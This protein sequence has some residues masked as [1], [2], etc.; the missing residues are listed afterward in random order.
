MAMKAPGKHY[1][2]GITLIEL[3]QMFPDEDAARKW[4][5]E[6]RWPNG[7]RFCP[8]CGS[9]KVS[10]VQT[11]KPLPYWCTDCREYFSIKTGSVMHRSKVP[12]HKWAIAIYLMSTSLK[13]V[14]SM[15]LHRDLG[16]TQKTAWLMAQKIRTG[17]MQG[18]DM[19][20][21]PVEVDETYIGGKER[22]KHA[23]KKLRAGRGPVGKTAVVGMKDRSTNQ[24]SAEVVRV[25]EEWGGS[26]DKPTLQGFVRGNAAPGA[27]LF[28]DDN[29]CYHDMVDFEHES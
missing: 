12:L 3:F 15:K 16:I 7:E 9:V 19:M 25:G 27:M 24:V 13:G 8:C 20:C 10:R 5:E 14:S 29:P 6:I 18:D 1:R 2:K 23:D 21:G 11:G 4:F 17:W 26:P 28:T 22:N